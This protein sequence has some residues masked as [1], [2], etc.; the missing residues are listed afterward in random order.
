M[1]VNFK[2]RYQQLKFVNQLSP[3]E[4][5]TLTSCLLNHANCRPRTRAHEILLGNK[6]YSIKEISNIFSVQRDAVSMWLNLWDKLEL[7][8]LFDAARSGRPSKL[9]H[10]GIYFIRPLA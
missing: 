10:D 2:I 8:A 7:S 6:G 3:L 9:P 1:D 4:V 5:E